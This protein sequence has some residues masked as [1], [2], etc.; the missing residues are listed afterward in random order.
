MP[1]KLIKTPRADVDL[2]RRASAHPALQPKKDEA[3][4]IAEEASASSLECDTRA[5]AVV[6]TTLPSRRARIDNDSTKK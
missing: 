2:P 4:R 6:S 3:S 5:S 1:S